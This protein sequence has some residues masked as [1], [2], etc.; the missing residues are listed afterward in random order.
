MT[1]EPRE[2]RLLRSLEQ[3]GKKIAIES[4]PTVLDVRAAAG[5]HARRLA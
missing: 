1:L 5:H 4:V 3:A 2:S